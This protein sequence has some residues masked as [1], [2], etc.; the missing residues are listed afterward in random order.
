MAGE[1]AWLQAQ[2]ESLA[3]LTGDIYT[4]QEEKDIFWRQRVAIVDR[5]LD[6]AVVTL[7]D[8]APETFGWSRLVEMVE[9][10]GSSPWFVVFVRKGWAL[11]LAGSLMVLCALAREGVG[12][13]C[14]YAIGLIR[15]AGRFTL[16]GLVLS[17][18]P[19][20]TAGG[21]LARAKEA[22]QRGDRAEA[23]RAL[24]EAAWCMPAI[25]QDGRFVLQTGLLENALGQETAEAQFYR[26]RV[27][28]D[29]GFVHQAGDTYLA[30][31][32]IDSGSSVLKREC[33]KA[34]L[35]QAINASNSGESETAGDLFAKILNADPCNLKANYA[36]QLACLRRGD[37]EALA[38]LQTRMAQVY[39]YFNTPTKEVI[40]ADGYESLAYVKFQSGDASGAIEAWGQA[41]RQ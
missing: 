4:S 7:P 21:L 12:D 11:A 5:P 31:L 14:S 33:I 38:R 22:A 23:L 35:R 19:T 39:R 26:A 3:R 28:E 25:S 32:S 34:L 40:L 15:Y 41:K 20:L 13:A 6:S 2:H 29:R 37:A 10:Y 17:L 24:R 16:M 9:W 30:I 27:R 18:V 8:W 1:A 36:L